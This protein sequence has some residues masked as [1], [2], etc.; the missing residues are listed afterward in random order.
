MNAD[1]RIGMETSW[2]ARQDGVQLEF[3]MSS[4]HA[5]ALFNFL[6]EQ[7]SDDSYLQDV[8]DALGAAIDLDLEGVAE[9]YKQYILGERCPELYSSS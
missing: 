2:E 4:H 6:C 7:D 9:D 1:E 8:R 5:K 3:G